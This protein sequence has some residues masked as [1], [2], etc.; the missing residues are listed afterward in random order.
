[1]FANT[2]IGQWF[3]YGVG[4]LELAG[5]VGVMIPPLSGLAALGLVCQM[6]GATLTNLFVFGTSPLFT[7]SLLMV[8]ARAG[9][10]QL[11]EDQGPEGQ[12]PALNRIRA[13][14]RHQ[15]WRRL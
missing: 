8:S 11:D 10:E 7:V 13:S 15:E 12:D 9:L 5:A 1:M 2:G 14:K 3:R 6:V 4:A